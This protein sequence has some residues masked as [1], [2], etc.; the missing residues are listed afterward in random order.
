MDPQSS[1]LK[2]VFSE[3]LLEKESSKNEQGDGEILTNYFT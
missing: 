1:S 3:S 2:F